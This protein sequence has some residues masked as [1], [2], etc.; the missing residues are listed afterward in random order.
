MF[1][2]VLK[3]KSVKW[4]ALFQREKKGAEMVEKTFCVESMIH[5]HHRKKWSKAKIYGEGVFLKSLP[6]QTLKFLA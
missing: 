6:L 4:L 1:H 2:L 3:K 5:T